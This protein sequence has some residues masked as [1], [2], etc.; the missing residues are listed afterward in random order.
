[1]A[2]GD[3]S[4]FV[5]ISNSPQE[6]FRIGKVLGR[7]LKGGD[8]VALTGELGAGKTSLTQGIA[9]GLGVPDSYA[10]TSPTFTL[11]N[12]YPG[13][14]APLYHV[15]VYRLA[16]PADLDET[17]YEECLLGNGVLVIEWAERILEAVP[18]DSLFVVISLLDENVR[19]IEFSGCPDRI[20]FWERAFREGGGE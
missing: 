11:I 8:C 16:G 17:G 12:E 14:D 19:K 18:D 7:F 1:M 6:T 2:A 15:D 9:S 10:V 5:L 4:S 3:R 20:G 13:R